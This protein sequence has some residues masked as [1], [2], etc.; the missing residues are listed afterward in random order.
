MG[1]GVFFNHQCNSCCHSIRKSNLSVEIA[2]NFSIP[3]AI[4]ICIPFRNHQRCCAALCCA[5]CKCKHCS[6]EWAI[7]LSDSMCVSWSHHPRCS[8]EFSLCFSFKERR[9][10]R[11]MSLSLDGWCIGVCCSRELGI[12]LGEGVCSCSAGERPVPGV[13]WARPNPEPCCQHFEGFLFCFVF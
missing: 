8:Q 7:S 9:E 10:L 12:V 6:Y 13:H 11:Q 4:L 2:P 1:A 5:V 3:I